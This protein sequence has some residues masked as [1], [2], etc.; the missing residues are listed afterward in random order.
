METQDKISI[1]EGLI[2]LLWRQGMCVLPYTVL[3]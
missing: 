1:I 2:T 3:G